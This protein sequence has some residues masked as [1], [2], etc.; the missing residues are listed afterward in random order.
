MKETY[1]QITAGALAGLALAGFAA[2][3]DFVFWA[4]LLLAAGVGVGV[5]FTIPGTKPP[6]KVE[7]AP[8]VTQKDLDDAIKAIRRH[9]ERFT[10]VARSPVRPEVAEALRDIVKHLNLISQNFREDPGDLALA[11][12]FLKEYLTRADRVADQY[13]RLVRITGGGRPETFAAV[14][15]GIFQMRHACRLLYQRC[16]E[17]DLENLETESETLKALIEIADPRAAVDQRSES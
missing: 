1:R 14:E 7:L 3:L 6:E 13:A 5:Y 17:N 2:A 8:G 4:D 10:R 12:P 11:G 9:R 16:L 15:Q